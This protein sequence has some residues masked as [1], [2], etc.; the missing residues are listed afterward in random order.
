MSRNKITD[1]LNI[2]DFIKNDYYNLLFT[3]NSTEKLSDKT[4]VIS[5]G[6]NE[7]V[8]IYNVEDK[9]IIDSLVITSDRFSN[10]VPLP[11]AQNVATKERLERSYYKSIHKVIVGKSTFLV[12]T[13]ALSTEPYDLDGNLKSL[14]DKEQSVI[15][16]DL[17][18][19]NKVGEY[20]LPKDVFDF[21]TGFVYNNRIYFLLSNPNSTNNEDLMKFVGY[22]V[23]KN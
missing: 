12:R 7:K 14:Y 22:E 21:R 9:Q 20:Y 13:T 3:L 2:A 6:V 17:S 19:R 5:F 23:R 1:N 11:T 15:I 8:F 16:Y 10:T 18:N 4:A